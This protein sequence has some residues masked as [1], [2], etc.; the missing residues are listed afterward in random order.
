MYLLMA[1]VI[2]FSSL[3]SLRHGFKKKTLRKKN[4][5][6]FQSSHQ[7][8]MKNVVECPREFFAY[9]NALKTYSECTISTYT[10]CKMHTKNRLL[11]LPLLQFCVSSAKKFIMCIFPF[12]YRY[13]SFVKAKVSPNLNHIT[14]LTKTDCL[15]FRTKNGPPKSMGS[16]KY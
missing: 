6:F 8:D 1:D 7:V 11:K 16:G 12:F 3:V 13:I 10:F 9:F 5:I 2:I 15:Q 4:C 14:E